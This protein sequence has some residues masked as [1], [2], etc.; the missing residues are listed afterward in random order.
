VLAVSAAVRTTPG[1]ATGTTNTTPAALGKNAPAPSFEL[2]RLG[3]G[4]PVTLAAVRGRPVIINFFASWCTDCQ[5]EL[6]AF[7]VASRHLAG[8][9]EFIGIDTNDDATATALSLLRHAGDHYPSG[10]DGNGQT[11]D[12]YLVGA[13]PETFF[14]DA[15]GR[16][17][18]FSPGSE[19]VAGLLAGAAAIMRR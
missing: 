15:S 8:K 6:A 17:I 18:S 2:P 5:K 14:V 7:A 3:G 4:A 9:V 19:T 1:A 11:A 16:I 13:L 10:V 12:R